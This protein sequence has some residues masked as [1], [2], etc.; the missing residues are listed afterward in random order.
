MMKELFYKWFGLTPLPCSSCEF[1]R[2]QLMGSE[3]E[4]RELLNR[5]LDQGKPEPSTPVMKEEEMRPFTPQFVPWRVKQQMLE[6]EDRK[7]AQLLRGKAEEIAELEKELG[8][9]SQKS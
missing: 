5:L 6:A 1:L 2:L 8:V 7:T 4:R 3:R 9:A